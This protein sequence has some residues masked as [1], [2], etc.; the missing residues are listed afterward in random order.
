MTITSHDEII[1]RLKA[2]NPCHQFVQDGIP[3]TDKNSSDRVV[4]F[5]FDRDEKFRSIVVIIHEN[6][7]FTILN[8][9][10]SQS[11]LEAISNCIQ[12]KKNYCSICDSM[13]DLVFH[14]E[15]CN[16]LTCVMCQMNITK[17]PQCRVETDAKRS[18]DQLLK[19]YTSTGISESC[20]R[21]TISDMKVL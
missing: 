13:V 4:L 14:C 9:N 5:H 6:A 21:K 3:R 17:C 19:H 1:G 10:P 8:S 20:A 15:D 12:K 16:F 7:K 2:M 11:Y 18:L